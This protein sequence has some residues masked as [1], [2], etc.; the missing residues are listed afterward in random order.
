[1]DF[2]I[3]AENGY[4]WIR[5]YDEPTT[6]EALEA[7]FDSL[8]GN[9]RLAFDRVCADLPCPK[10][11]MEQHA[12]EYG[13]TKDI[14]AAAE[15]FCPAP[16]PPPVKYFPTHWNCFKNSF[17][18]AEAN[19]LIYVEGLAISPTGPQI[20]AWNS[21]NGRDVIDLTWPCQHLNKYFGI[22]LVP[23]KLRQIYEIPWAILGRIARDL[24]P[25]PNR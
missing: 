4:E 14:L 9:D 16:L 1:M 8:A 13:W 15:L 18:K 5:F 23:G 17:A 20:H 24:E 2:D 22:N 6:P 19:G 7:F 21:T 11:Y 12:A 10:T 3:V 25:K